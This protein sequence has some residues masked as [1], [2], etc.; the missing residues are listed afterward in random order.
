MPLHLGRWRLPEHLDAEAICVTDKHVFIAGQPL[1]ASSGPE[2]W[3]FDLP[4]P[5]AALG[6]VTQKM[7]NY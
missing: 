7:L 1:G 2:V 4:A 6:K 3:R 5:V